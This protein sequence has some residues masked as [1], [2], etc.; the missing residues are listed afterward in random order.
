MANKSRLTYYEP[1]ER[2][3]KVKMDIIMRYEP[4][5]VGIYC[6]LITISSGKSLS[7]DFLSKRIG[8]S[9]EKMRKTIV[10]LEGEGYV[11]RKALHDEKGKMCGWDYSLFAEPVSPEE[12]TKAGCRQ[13]DLF[14]TRVMDSPCYGKTHKTENPEDYNIDNINN[15][16]ID[17]PVN[18]EIDKGS[19]EPMDK[20]D[21]DI[22]VEKMRKRYPRIMRME[23]P[24]TL[25]QAKKL[26]ERFDRDLI[27]KVL[28]DMENWKPLLKT[29]VS[30]YRTLSTWCQKELE[31]S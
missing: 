29:K 13:S 7:I 22:Y 21:D 12:R 3:K 4:I 20:S 15:S 28:D 9:K 27:A 30:A 6:K 14:D 18:K 25:E 1:K 31:R 11:T 26:K 8:V 16:I 10:F 19:C 24:L 23:Q 2:F 5:V 17:N